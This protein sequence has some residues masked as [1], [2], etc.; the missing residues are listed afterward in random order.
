MK[1]DCMVCGR[2]AQ[3][4]CPTLGGTICSV[5]CGS[6]RGSE[7][8]CAAECQY[9]PLGTAAIDSFRKIDN[10]VVEKM[11]LLVARHLG[12]VAFREAVEA[13]ARLAKAKDDEPGASLN[14]AVANVALLKM[15]HEPATAGKVVYDVLR[16]QGFPGL[17]N[18]ERVLLKT[19][20]GSLPTVIE[21][22]R[23]VD[24][25]FLEVVDMFEPDGH[26]EKLLDPALAGHGLPRFAR[27]L[28]WLTRYPHFCRGNGG[29]LMIP[30]IMATDYVERIRKLAKAA[31]L[32]DPRQYL[33]AHAA[34]CQGWVD[35]MYRERMGGILRRSDIHQCVLVYDVKGDHR[36]VLR[37]LDSKPDFEPSATGTA[38]K[39]GVR[40]YNWLRRGESRKLE[41]QMPEAFRSDDERGSVGTVGTIRLSSNELTVEAFSRQKMDFAKATVKDY[42]GSMLQ[43]RRELVRDVGKEMAAELPK[44]DATPSPRRASGI[45]P[46][47]ERQIMEQFFRQKYERFPDE[48]VPMLGGLTP[49]QASKRPELR[50]KLVELM[51]LHMRGLDQEY[52]GRGIK[53]SLDALLDEL[54]LAELK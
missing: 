25:R 22:Q 28:V 8:E 29:C 30:D 11:T 50:G 37:I 6:K 18:D 4:P 43:L 47:T 42:F 38:T 32:N 26:T 46:E 48:S 49:R 14:N 52:R 40:T 34:E 21:V 54:G 3:R 31:R 1:A 53:I 2:R 16:A 35:A 41:D 9:Y 10:Q 17:S 12:D 19:L 5:C 45:D 27:L 24:D 44:H 20:E 39:T 51:K 13:H 23:T 33:L 15:F 7:I 36:E